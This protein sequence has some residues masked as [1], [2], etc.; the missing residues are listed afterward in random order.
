MQTPLGTC[1][2]QTH[3]QMRPV[4]YFFEDHQMTAED[5]EFNRIEREAATHKAAVHST[6]TRYE[7]ETTMSEYIKGFNDC[8]DFVLTQIERHPHMTAI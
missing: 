8:Y 6:V 3:L 5:E 7:S 2:R 4:Q 1:A